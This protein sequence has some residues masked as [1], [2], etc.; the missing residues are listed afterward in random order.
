RVARPRHGAAPDEVP[1]PPMDNAPLDRLTLLT[2]L[3]VPSCARQTIAPQRLLEVC[4][5]P[6]PNPEDCALARSI[7]VA[8]CPLCPDA[9][10]ALTWLKE[11]AHPRFRPM[12]AVQLARMD[13]EAARLPEASAALRA[14]AEG[15]SACVEIEAAGV[16]AC[17]VSAAGSEQRV[18]AEIRVLEK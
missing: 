17:V 6:A 18:D 5:T 10:A 14:L 11:Q 2:Q 8:R 9:R 13:C 12:A 4:D 7:Y 15:P 3:F 16:A 1:C